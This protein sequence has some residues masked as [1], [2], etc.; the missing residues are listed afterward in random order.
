M[1]V[2]VCVRACVC[3]CVCV[4][5]V[6]HTHLAIHVAGDVVAADLIAHA[7][8]ALEVGDGAH[9]QILRHATPTAHR[10]VTTLFPFDSSTAVAPRWA[11]PRCLRQQTHPQVGGAKRLLDEVKAH[12]VL[13]LL[14]HLQ[15]SHGARPT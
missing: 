8:A 5:S 12:L 1:R 3:V 15:S 10:L 6:A 11:R 13:L 14:D 2:C 4:R 7:R 9:I